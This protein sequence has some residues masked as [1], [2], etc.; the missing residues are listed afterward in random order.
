MRI[1]IDARELQGR[2]T[3]VGRYLRN[4]IGTWIRTTDDSLVLYFN[5]P[6][7]LDPLL[8]HPLVLKRALGDSPTRGLL[9]QERSLP[10]AA[11]GDQLDVFFAPA[12]AC[13]LS[14]IL[15][16]VTTVHDMSF[17]SI[18]DDFTVA[19]GFRRRLLV[20]MSLRASR[21]V[22]AVSDFTRREV[23]SH[24][25][26]VAGRVTAILHGA[27]DEASPAPP[28]DSSRTALGIRGPLLV[29]VGSIL[30]RRRLPILFRAVGILRK[31][32]PQIVLDVVG[33]NR[34][35]PRLD[36]E[37]VVADLG[38]QAHVRL[39][40]FVSEEDLAARYAAAD[41]AVYL[42]EYEGFGLPVVE[43]MARGVPV[44]TSARPATGELF[45]E[46]ALLTNPGDAGE[47][48]GAIRELL[49]EPGCAESLRAR[50][51]AL[52][53]R[54]TWANTAAATRDVLA[55]AADAR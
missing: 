48:A 55:N 20:A 44:V 13:P 43:A 17:F 52:A 40:G 4:L 14:L 54:L 34:T 51:R 2:T 8:D 21:Q 35:H 11:C 24:F 53:G 1:G 31:T 5:G 41:V 16:R 38:V 15:P 10:R 33:E 18:P 23:V 6:A 27:D 19:D 25:P 9:W 3:G 22:I 30:N 26:E 49:D 47:V 32:H 7:P 29:S 39:S 36:L 50:G 37:G 45:A 28:R 42:S 12:Y 46:A